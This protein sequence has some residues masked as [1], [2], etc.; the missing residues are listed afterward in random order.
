M[1]LIDA[2]ALKKNLLRIQ[3]A[4]VN[5]K[6]PRG[7]AISDAW[8][9]AYMLIL[10]EYVK[11]LDEMPSAS[12]SFDA[13]DIFRAYGR[14]YSKGRNDILKEQQQMEDYCKNDCDT[15]NET[16]KEQKMENSEMTREE[17][18][19]KIIQ[20]LKTLDAGLIVTMAEK[21]RTDVIHGTIKQGDKSSMWALVD[22]LGYYSIKGQTIKYLPEYQELITLMKKVL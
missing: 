12:C 6:A 8:K 1:R 21:L 22:D 9:P 11:M 17:I 20:D 15:L 19:D 18:W 2:D 5:Q 7:S 14:G 3:D 13:Y 10:D 16:W 4:I